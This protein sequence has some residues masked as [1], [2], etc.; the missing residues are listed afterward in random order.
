MIKTFTDKNTLSTLIVSDDIRLLPSNFYKQR[1][2]DGYW[3]YIIKF[4]VPKLHRNKGIATILFNKMIKWAN[5]NKHNLILEVTPYEGSSYN[6][7][8]K[9]YEKFGFFYTKYGFMEKRYVIN[10]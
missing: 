2:F 7:L 1:Y 10:S 9:F 6:K 8:I 4:Y 3:F 5:K